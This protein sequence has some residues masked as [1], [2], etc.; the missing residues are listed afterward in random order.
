M[1]Y[2]GIILNAALLQSVG[3]SVA[4][5]GKLT[6]LSTVLVAY[7]AFLGAAIFYVP[8]RLS[9]HNGPP[10]EDSLRSCIGSQGAWLFGKIVLPL[11]ISAW[12]CYNTALALGCMD[13]SLFHKDWSPP[14]L[15]R[16]A[17]IGLVWLILIAPAAKEPLPKLAR[18]S[19][20]TTKVSIAVILGLALSSR[21]WVS[22]TIAD[23]ANSKW[24]SAMPLEPLV[25]LWVAPP[26]LLAGR[27]THDL[28]ISK[29]ATLSIIAIGI[30]IPVLFAVLSAILTIAGAEGISGMHP[31]KLPSYLM[32]AYKRPDQMG[33]VKVLLMTFTLL[34]AT[35]FA[36]NLGVSVITRRPRLWI[37]AAFTTGIIALTWFV[38]GY[39][40]MR[41]WEYTAV[42]FVPL[43]GVL[44]AAYLKARGHAFVFSLAHQRLA[45]LAWVT[46]C[47]I[48]FV[49]TWSERYPDAAGLRPAW[50]I[51]G[52]F[53]SFAATWLLTRTASH[54]RIGERISPA[55]GA[56]N[57]DT[58]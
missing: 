5:V 13:A 4:L 48:T 11:W 28:K 1:L 26:L 12:F 20:F 39:W 54:G 2:A 9:A 51:L 44:C 7:G 23:Y 40:I 57:P 27:L 29:H 17:F 21:A 10:I 45:L 18:F 6:R 31:M 53:V 56:P 42:P 32:Y 49:P 38:K 52:W 16:R 22:E 8:A 41:A 36:A 35:R 34:A 55:T 50:V 46:G 15:L 25:L 19:M 47:V 43:A 58:M 24:E 33:W 14:S 30:V 37:A 3:N